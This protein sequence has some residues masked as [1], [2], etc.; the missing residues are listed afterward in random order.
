MDDLNNLRPT[1][2]AKI[3]CGKKHFAALGVDFKEATKQDLSDIL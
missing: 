2:K 1:E 3:T